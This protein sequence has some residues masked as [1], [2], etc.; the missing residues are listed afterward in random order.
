[1][2]HVHF[3]LERGLFDEGIAADAAVFRNSKHDRLIAHFKLA[4]AS[5]SS[6]IVL[7]G[8]AGVGKTTLTSTALRAL[9]TRLALAWLNGMPTNAA[10]LLELI[11][12]ELGVSTLRTTRIERLQLWRQFQAEMRATDSRLLIVAERTEDLSVE[13]LHALDQLTAPDAVGNPGANLVLLGHAGIHEHLAAPLLDSLRQRIRLR[14]ELEPF[15]E[16][17]L[18]DYLRHQTARAG[19]NYDHI[20]A[21]GTVAALYRYSNGVARLVNTLCES[22]LDIAAVQHHKQLTPDFVARTAVSLLGLAEP[23]S[24][25]RPVASAAAPVSGPPVETRPAPRAIPTTAPPAIIVERRSEP[26]VPAVPPSP[27]ARVAEAAPA[28]PSIEVSAAATPAAASTALSP[29]PASAAAMTAAPPKPVEIEYD[30][31]ATDVADVAVADFPI[32]TDAVEP[33]ALAPAAKQAASAPAKTTPA[34]QA[35]TTA[36]PQ[37]RT[38]GPAPPPAPVAAAP[39]KPAP[40]P[41]SRVETAYTAARPATKPTAAPAESAAAPALTPLPH[42][43][44]LKPSAPAPGEQP[45]PDPQ[46][47]DELRQTQTMRAIA[48][49]K[50]ID[51]ISEIDAETLFSDAELDL[52]S[53]ALASAAEWPDDDEPATAAPSRPEAAKAAKPAAS[54][55]ETAKAA[56]P[57]EEDPFD[58]FGLGDDAPL[59]LIDDSTLPPHARKTAAR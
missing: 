28:P 23:A 48:G 4:L 29:S 25:A 11:L 52:V 41:A 14:A 50:S 17:E 49:A 45:S 1:M 40:K 10:E 21:P 57:A 6:S 54:R 31:S 7:Q 16:A 8:P 55:P 5:A 36:P 20:F 18:Q 37:S 19:G 30:G 15:T 3:G 47:D 26:R 53:A 33:P 35:P 12:I 13:V 46:G 32:L 34:P 58:L 44:A 24:A 9:S 42:A 56:A 51:D 22:A 43:A 38:L 27:P 2:Y 59:E 39:A